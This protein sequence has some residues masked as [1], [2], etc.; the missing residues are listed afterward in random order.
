MT[1]SSQLICSAASQP[2]DAESLERSHHQQ[3]TAT[4]PGHELRHSKVI[5]PRKP[6]TG[7]VD[8]AVRSGH[9]IRLTDLNPPAG[10]LAI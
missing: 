3:S 8:V 5:W 10:S 7:A 6:Q 9:T 1:A 4:Q 2:N